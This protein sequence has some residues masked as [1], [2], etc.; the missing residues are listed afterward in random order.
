MHGYELRKRL[1]TTV[2]PLFGVSFGS[3]YPCLKRMQTSG[4]VH[5][6]EPA[7]APRRRKRSGAES[8]GG[9]KRV[10]RVKKVY[11]ITPDGGA[12]LWPSPTPRSCPRRLRCRAR[13]GLAAGR[14]PSPTARRRRMG[15]AVLS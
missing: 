3:L 4:L 7:P 6:T 12:I 11:E 9:Q 2:G 5:E 1:K 14:S 10:R 15:R 8:A 13:P